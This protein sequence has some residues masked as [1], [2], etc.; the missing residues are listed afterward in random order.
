MVRRRRVQG[1]V[2]HK[3]AGHG[4][5]ATTQRHLYPDV[6]K[7]TAAGAALSAHLSALRAPRFPPSPIMVT[8]RHG[9]DGLVPTG[10]QKRSRAGFRFL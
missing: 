1:H 10:P 9:Q 5:P 3:I 7:I 4:S 6:H 8:H 2:P